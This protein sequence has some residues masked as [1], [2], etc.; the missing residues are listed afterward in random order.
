MGLHCHRPTAWQGTHGPGPTC[1][2]MFKVS[3]RAGPN[4]C[5]S[6]LGYG[7][8]CNSL[9]ILSALLEGSRVPIV[10][11]LDETLLV[12]SSMGALELHYRRCIARVRYAPPLLDLRLYASLQQPWKMHP[13][14]ALCCAL[15]AAE[16]VY[17]KSARSSNDKL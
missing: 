7:I 5:P 13:A 12:A 6:F 1:N 8:S 4:P 17:V 11:D 10:L 2:I 15:Q 9:Q 14:F 16:C 3:L